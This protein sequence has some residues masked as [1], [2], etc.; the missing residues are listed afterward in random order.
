MR[1]T[2]QIY[3]DYTA[4]DFHVWKTLYERQMPLLRQYA[5]HAYLSSLDTVQFTGER[6]PDFSQ[7]NQI[8]ASLTGWG[9]HVVP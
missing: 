7:V 1:P 6:I 2:Q 3:S 5:C 8:L 4:E 9:I